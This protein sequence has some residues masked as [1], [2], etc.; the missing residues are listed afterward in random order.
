MVTVAVT[1]MMIIIIIIAV[2][3]MTIVDP[4]QPTN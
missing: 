2:N 3:V 1:T 4:L